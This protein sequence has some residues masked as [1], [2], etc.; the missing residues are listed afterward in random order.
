MILKSV[1]LVINLQLIALVVDVMG[2]YDIMINTMK[3]IILLLTAGWIICGCSEEQITSTHP[4]DWLTPGSDN[5]HIAKIQGAG[6]GGC[7]ACHGGVEKNDYFGGSSGVSCYQCHEGGPSGHPA[8]E[9]WM[10]DTT[11]TQFHGTEAGTVSSSYCS[12]CHSSDKAVG[13]TG[14]LCANCHPTAAKK[15]SLHCIQKPLSGG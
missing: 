8:W 7:Q 15:I 4:D 10:T 5:S 1:W 12:S 6:I 13:S 11:N 3:H 9:I 2:V 14:H